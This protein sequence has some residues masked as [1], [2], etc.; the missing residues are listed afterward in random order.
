MLPISNKLLHQNSASYKAFLIFVRIICIFSSGG[1]PYGYVTYV[2]DMLTCSPG[3][4]V[5]IKVTQ[6]SWVDAGAWQKKAKISAYYFYFSYKGQKPLTSG[7]I[8]GKLKLFA[9]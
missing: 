6:L 8:C 3:Y 1:I 7:Q 4:A 9:T 5:I 2:H